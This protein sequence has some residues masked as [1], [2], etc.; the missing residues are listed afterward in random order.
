M[1]AGR[2]PSGQVDDVAVLGSCGG[3]DQDNLQ[4]DA[5]G[6]KSHLFRDLVKTKGHLKHAADLLKS[7][8]IRVSFAARVLAH[9]PDSP[10]TRA[11]KLWGDDENPFKH[12]II[13]RSEE[14]KTWRETMAIL[15]KNLRP[16]TSGRTVWRGWYFDSASV[17]KRLWKDLE[18]KAIFVNA[19]VGMSASRSRRIACRPEFMNEQG[20]LWEIRSPR[21]AR[22]LA[23]IFRAIGAKY[24]E[25]R[26][27]VFPKGV[28]F[29]LV[30]KPGWRTIR[31][32]G[33]AKKVRHY[34]VQEKQ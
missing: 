17:R 1:L 15:L 4:A 27:V 26:E 19:R 14:A 7:S 34:V 8:N 2:S 6:E 11:L 18:I 20:A 23:P 24:P 25:Q 28:R 22:D 16:E 21:S 31:R 30:G 10:V 3:S 5:L 9:E 13:S 12:L 29:E 32:D 33:Q